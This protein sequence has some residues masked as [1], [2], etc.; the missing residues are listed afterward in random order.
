MAINTYL[1]RSTA[2]LDSIMQFEEQFTLKYCGAGKR[3]HF[4]SPPNLNL[5]NVVSNVSQIVYS[6]YGLF[7]LRGHNSLRIFGD[8]SKNAT[9]F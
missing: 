2:A 7:S 3:H 9:T 6:Y 8:I 4:L 5:R 1:V